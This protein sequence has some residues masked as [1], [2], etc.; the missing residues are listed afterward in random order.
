MTLVERVAR[1]MWTRH[2]A[3]IVAAYEAGWTGTTLDTRW[4]RLDPDGQRRFLALAEEAISIALEAAA[5]VVDQCNEE[6]PFQAI[7]AASRI[8]ALISDPPPERTP[9]AS[10]L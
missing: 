5:A 8:R 3:E 7:G 2:C 1:A 4:E 9:E 10:P 6:G